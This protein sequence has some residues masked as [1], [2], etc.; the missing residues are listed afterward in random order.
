MAA[1]EMK[2]KYY[3]SKASFESFPIAPS[4]SIETTPLNE[5]LNLKES[6]KR[7]IETI[8]QHEQKR[9]NGKLHEGYILSASSFDSKKLIGNFAPYKHFLAEYVDP[10]LKAD[11][12][13]TP[14]SMSAITFS[15]EN[16][17]IGKRAD[18]VAE[19]P[20]RFELA[21]SGGINNETL[22]EE[23]NVDLKAQLIQELEDETGIPKSG[24]KKVKFFALIKDHLRG[25]IEL[26]ATI[27]L[28]TITVLS[29][30]N[31]YSQLISLPKEE[32]K[33]FVELHK[34]NFVPLSLELL[35]L[36]NLI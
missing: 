10:S 1:I 5:P 32:I 20:M 9:R 18:W 15:G 27:E 19:Y 2:K 24:V 21:P 33:G 13:I 36:Q 12:N 16:I 22:D 4:F 25:S 6:K 30:T 23:G 31:E 29:S 3:K 11:L 34:E 8:W 28:K 35:K 26:V 7:L 14:V 17:I